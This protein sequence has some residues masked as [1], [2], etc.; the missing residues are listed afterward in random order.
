[1]I[2]VEPVFQT[3][4]SPDLTTSGDLPLVLTLPLSVESSQFC[5][6]VTFSV[7]STPVSGVVYQGE[8]VQVQ[9]QV[10]SSAED[11]VTQET[12]FSGALTP[13]LTFT[14]TTSTFTVPVVEAGGTWLLNLDNSS[15]LVQYDPDTGY[16]MPQQDWDVVVH[17]PYAFV[18]T[19]LI[20][21]AVF[22]VS[23][24]SRVFTEPTQ[25]LGSVVTNPPFTSTAPLESRHSPCSRH[26]QV[27]FQLGAAH[28][29]LYHYDTVTWYL[30]PA[31][32]GQT[33][34]LL[35]VVVFD[36]GLLFVTSHGFVTV[37]ESGTT[38][39]RRVMSSASSTGT[40]RCPNPGT[41]RVLV[42]VDQDQVW[43]NT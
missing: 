40:S 21:P 43:E 31:V 5:N 26:L 38:R 8:G 9:V 6:S 1:M 23:L 29:G 7:T 12:M 20:K 2:E 13:T 24:L 35:E 22:S 37:S 14:N 41:D 19:C 11:Q 32:G 25:Y 15:L 33:T 30:S 4:H 16:L 42:A 3:L 17:F 28:F 39:R 36:K 27:V 10:V 34:S 18:E